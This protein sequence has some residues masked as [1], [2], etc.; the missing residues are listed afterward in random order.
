MTIA[1]DWDVKHQFKQTNKKS[2]LITSWTDTVW[3]FK[4][5]LYGIKME[6]IPIKRLVTYTRHAIIS[7]QSLLAVPRQQLL[8]RLGLILVLASVSVISIL[9]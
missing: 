9:L 2:N 4:I 6:V 5:F 8:L 3:A 1:V 7:L